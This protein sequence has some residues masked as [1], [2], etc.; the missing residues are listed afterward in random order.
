MIYLVSGSVPQLSDKESE[1]KDMKGY[2]T[3]S[4]TP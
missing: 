3:F 1:M 4:G 2:E